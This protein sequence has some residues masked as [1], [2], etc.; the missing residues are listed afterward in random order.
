MLCHWRPCG[1]D[2]APAGSDKSGFFSPPSPCRRK[3][4]CHFFWHTFLLRG[5]APLNKSTLSTF[6]GRR[7]RPRRGMRGNRQQYSRRDQDKAHSPGQHAAKELSRSDH[8]HARQNLTGTSSQDGTDSTSDVTVQMRRGHALEDFCGRMGMAKDAFGADQKRRIRVSTLQAK[9]AFFPAFQHVAPE[10]VTSLGH[11]NNDFFWTGRLTPPTQYP[12]HR[13]ES[14]IATLP[15]KPPT[16]S[17]RLPLEFSFSG[18]IIQP[19]QALSGLTFAAIRTVRK[20][21]F[22]KSCTV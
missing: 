17:V 8:L 18:D 5:G 3:C 4:I 7:V 16:H 14:S 12:K 9:S 22:P 19:I 10:P 20:S 13:G 6:S 2:G 1:G 11:F 21:R 15:A